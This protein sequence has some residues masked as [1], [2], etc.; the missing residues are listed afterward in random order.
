MAS[1]IDNVDEDVFIEI[2]K[3]LDVASLKAAALVCK[4]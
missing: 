1:T 4:E 3:Y 2:F